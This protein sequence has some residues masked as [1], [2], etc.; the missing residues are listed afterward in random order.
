MRRLLAAWEMPV[1][2]GLL[3]IHLHLHHRFHGPPFDYAGLA[4]AAA[5]SWIGL[6]GPGEPVLLAA[7]I[8]AARNRLDLA[9]VVVVAFAAATA[10]GVIGWAIGLRFGRAILTVPGPLHAPRLR[11]LARGEDMFERHPVIA[12]LVTPAFVAGIHRV[13]SRV[14]QPINLVSAAVW[15]VGIGVGGYFVGPPVLDVFSDLGTA[16]TVIAIL[17]ILGG[18]GA[19]IG[20]RRRR[21]RRASPAEAETSETA[22]AASRPSPR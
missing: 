6:P 21:A 20:R 19:G 10:G 15:A 3:H 4:L 13:P 14:Y 12:I 7:A 11:M 18:I 22:T 2:F 5:A 8:L 1:A 9:S 16:L 17:A